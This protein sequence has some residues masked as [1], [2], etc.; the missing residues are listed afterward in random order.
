[1][2]D[3][4]RLD[5]DE[6]VVRVDHELVGAAALALREHAGRRW[7]EV[8]DRVRRQALR[9]TRSSPPVAAM[10]P[11]GPVQVSEQV[12]VAQVRDALA[13]LRGARVEDIEV[14]TDAGGRYAGVVLVV[15]AEYGVPLLP[16]ADRLRAAAVDRLRTVLGPVTPPVD[17]QT[18]Q[19]HVDDVHRPGDAAGLSRG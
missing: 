15:S 2:S 7:V 9:A 17:V 16:V 18:L 8:A 14:H 12:L 6:D 3:D 4:T 10:A 11:G 5:L 1:M 13:H 19:V